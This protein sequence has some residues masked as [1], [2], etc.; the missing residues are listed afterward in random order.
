[1]Q[2]GDIRFRLRDESGDPSNLRLHSRRCHHTDTSAVGHTAAHISHIRPVTKH[3]IIALKRTCLFIRRQR[4]AGQR[5]LL[6]LQRSRLQ[7]PY[8]GRNH[9]AGFEQHYISRHQL[10]AFDLGDLPSP[11]DSG[12]RRRHA[13]ERFE[14][15]FSLIF[16]NDAQHRV[17]YNNQQYDDRICPFA[18]DSR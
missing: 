14:R 10:F 1:M 3:Q 11:A 5:R 7:Q 4:L 2:G 12:Q 8:V 16:L 13:F 6:G 9:I 15:L 17:Q 18:Q